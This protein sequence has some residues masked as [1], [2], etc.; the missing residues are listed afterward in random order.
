MMVR[1]SLLAQPVL[2]IRAVW[3]SSDPDSGAGVDL[4]E[5]RRVREAQQLEQAGAPY[6][7][8]GEPDEAGLVHGESVV[9]VDRLGTPRGRVEALVQ[10][11]TEAVSVVYRDNIHLTAGQAVVQH[12]IQQTDEAGL[13]RVGLPRWI[14]HTN[15]TWNLLPDDHLIEVLW[16]VKS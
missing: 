10:P 3:D 13:I 8:V 6:I 9:P 4:E 11:A 14:Y 7:C 15:P 16:P 1:R 5:I 2:C 12:L